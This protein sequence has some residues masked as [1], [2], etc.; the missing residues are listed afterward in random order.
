VAGNISFGAPGSPATSE[1][2][3]I[4]NE[5][6]ALVDGGADFPDGQLSL[7]DVS[8]AIGTPVSTAALQL[9]VTVTDESAS[10]TASNGMTFEAAFAIEQDLGEEGLIPTEFTD[11]VEE[12]GVDVD[13]IGGSDDGESDAGVRVECVEADDVDTETFPTTEPETSLAP[14]GS[15]T[16]YPETPPSPPS[17]NRITLDFPAGGG[18]VT[19]SSEWAVAVGDG[20]TTVA[21]TWTGTYDASAGTLAG[22]ADIT[23]TAPSGAVLGSGT[24]DWT[25]TFDA[26]TGV[27]TGTLESPDGPWT[28]EV[29]VQG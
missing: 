23:T 27:V 19:G 10:G 24:T 16:A 7:F 28:F 14:T 20:S 8:P 26:A 15:F 17:P 13:V 11:L 5:I 3:V 29:S 25:A 21:G 18:A 1:W 9:S 22:T 6:G 4:G 12:G 2:L